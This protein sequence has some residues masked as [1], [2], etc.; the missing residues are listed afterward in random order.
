[1]FHIGK[2]LPAL[3]ITLVWTSVSANAQP[4]G[5]FRWQLQ[6]YCNVVTVNVTQQNSIY[7]LDGTDDRC[8][9]SQAA[10]VVGVAFL[11]P[12]GMVGFGLSIV[13]PGGMPVHVEAT[14]D[15]TSLS[16][17]WRD[18][19]GQNGTFVFTPGA[20]SGGVPRPVPTSLLFP[21]SITSVHIVPG[22]IT[23]AQVANG[24]LTIAHQADAPRAAFASAPLAVLSGGNP[25]VLSATLTAPA[26]GR[27]IANASGYFRL[28]DPTDFDTARCSITTDTV[29][30]TT[31]L[32]LVEEATN[33]TMRHVPFAGTRGF[34]VAAGA[35][36]INLVCEEISGDVRVGDSN[37]TLMFLAG[38]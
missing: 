36:T 18:S 16:G 11:H 35:V 20:G 25:F 32:I 7:T 28:E 3:L 22:T 5:T 10:S 34:T 2:T 38:S 30:D 37:L 29:V 24:S 13:L 19:A 4:I 26:S 12:T 14:I 8:A 33:V 27:I 31:Q 9:A 21:A 15:M 17:T 1:M 6:P 23:G